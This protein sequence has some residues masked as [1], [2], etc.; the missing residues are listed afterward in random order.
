V[1]QVPYVEIKM[2]AHKCRHFQLRGIWKFQFVL[3]H[4]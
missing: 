2:T 4:L 3:R 1:Q